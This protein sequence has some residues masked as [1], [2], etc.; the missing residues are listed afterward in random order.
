MPTYGAGAAPAGLAYA[1]FGASSATPPV[2]QSYALPAV[3]IDT[4]QRDYRFDSNGNRLRM[5]SAQQ[6]VFLALCTVRGTS[7]VSNLG[8]DALPTV[9][10]ER[11][12]SLV[13]EAAERA[14][15]PYTRANPPLIRVVSI[16]VTR[17]TASSYRLAVTW[18]DT[19]DDYETTTEVPLG[20]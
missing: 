6:L 2:P 18:R 19:T 20:G 13:T 9:I 14:L 15:A 7:G 5:S 12:K 3:A 4:V 8:M 1:G 16:A 11:T 17:P 10:S